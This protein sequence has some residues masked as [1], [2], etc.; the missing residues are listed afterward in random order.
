MK[1]FKSFIKD[2][3]TWNKVLITVDQI[4]EEVWTKID[5]SKRYSRNKD[6]MDSAYGNLMPHHGE[7]YHHLRKYTAFSK[8]LNQRLYGGQELDRDEQKQVEGIDRIMKKTTTPKDVIVHSGLGFTPEHMPVHESG[9]IR[10]Q[11]PAYL[12]T[13]LSRHTAYGFAHEHPTSAH[14]Y[15]RIHAGEGKVRWIQATPEKLNEYQDIYHR[16]TVKGVY[17]GYMHPEVRRAKEEFEKSLGHVHPPSYNY[18]TSFMFKPHKH[19]LTIHVP[20]GSHGFYADP[21]SKHDGE[22]E[23]ILPRNSKILI[24][25]KPRLL[26]GRGDSVQAVNWRGHLVHDGFKPTRHD[27]EE[28]KQLSMDF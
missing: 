2:E 11:T 5:G 16:G 12:S 8:E 10:I 9:K 24:H 7:D 21:Y 13:S 26:R 27:N 4:N 19:M 3:D 22:H 28:P 25:P 14:S 20:A 15:F 17:L 18:S 6:A 1:N 23:V